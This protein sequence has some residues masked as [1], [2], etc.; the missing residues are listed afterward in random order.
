MKPVLSYSKAAKGMGIKSYT[1]KFSLWDAEEGGNMVW[2]EEKTV[3]TR[4]SEI[5]TYLGN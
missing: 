2:E 1:I 4:R 5:N 3:K